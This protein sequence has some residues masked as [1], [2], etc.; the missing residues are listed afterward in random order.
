LP[1]K[2]RRI[3][4]RRSLPDTLAAGAV[5]ATSDSDIYLIEVKV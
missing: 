1:V 2:R 5:V 3:S 4:P